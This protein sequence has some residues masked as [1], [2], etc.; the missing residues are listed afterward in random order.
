[1]IPSSS[2]FWMRRQ[3][4]VVDRP[5]LRPISATANGR[6]LLQERENLAVDLVQSDGGPLR[7]QIARL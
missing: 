3:H 4:G 1:M 2:I 7:N 6:V 5:T